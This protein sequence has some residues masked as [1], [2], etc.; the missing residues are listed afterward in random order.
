MMLYLRRFSRFLLTLPAALRLWI[1]ILST[2]V[3]QTLF[4]LLAPIEQNPSILA[5]PVVLAAWF[6]RRPGTLFCLGTLAIASW[7]YYAIHYRNYPLSREFVMAFVIG[8]LA[9]LITG[10]VVSTLR[11][12]FERV[13]ESKRKIAV[14]LEEQQRLHQARNLFIQH[15]NHELKTPLTSL[16]GYLELLLERNTQFDAETRATFLQ[17]ALSSCEELELLVSN[18]LESLQTRDE[19]SAPPTCEVPLLG[20]V[21]EVIRQADPRWHLEKRTRL[22][23][24]E[25]LHALAYPQYLR[26]LLRN[27]LSNAVKYAP[28]EDPI[29]I[30]A[31]RIDC[32]T[33]DT[34]QICVS[35]KDWGP[36]IPTD[37][38]HQLFGQ[39]VRLRRD[40][41]GHVRGSGLG[42]AISKQLVEAMGGRIWVESSGVPGEGSCFSFTLPAVHS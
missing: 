22:E 15:V 20:A 27:L 33:S 3:C 7:A 18:I 34:P 17:S 4:I 35:V 29:L 2:V 42:L 13:E 38:I 11:D 24:S 8:T 36:G 37:E 12:T 31:R 9:L 25:D 10:L 40:I 5:I 32:P 19:V 41:L 14:T 28:G 21:R 6:Y 39:F 26:Q 23:I 30:N 1:V 16:S